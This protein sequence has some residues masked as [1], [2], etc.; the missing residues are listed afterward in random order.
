MWAEGGCCIDLDKR[1]LILYGGEDIECDVLW[2]ETYMELLPYTWRGW[3][4]EW[5]WGELSQIARYAGVVGTQLEE[6]G[7]SCK[8]AIPDDRDWYINT[9]LECSTTQRPASTVAIRRN[10]AVRS[11]YTSESEPE[12]LLD[13]GGDIERVIERMSPGPLAYDDDEFLMGSLF[14]DYDAHEIWLWRTW[15]NNL[16]V[17]LPTYWAGWK[18][19]DCKYRYDAFFE[20]VPHFIDFAP[21]SENVYLG[22]I[23]DWVCSDRESF[24]PNGLPAEERSAIFEDV[25]T[26]YRADNPTPRQLP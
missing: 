26:R 21:R 17:D 5:S 25:L 20:S 15:D 19:H 6:I 7:C 8:V 3:T 23:E 9:F 11:I 18:L 2:L 16:E 12:A 4:V 14:L 10:G 22:K 13:L 24:A 1:H